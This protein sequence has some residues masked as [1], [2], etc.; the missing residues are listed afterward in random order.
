MEGKLDGIKRSLEKA[1][2]ARMWVPWRALPSDSLP[3]PQGRQ[4]GTARSGSVT[5]LALVRRV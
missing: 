2:S 4:T 1:T 5:S 3:T